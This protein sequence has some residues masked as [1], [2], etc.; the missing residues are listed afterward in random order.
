MNQGK[1]KFLM[2]ISIEA[3]TAEAA[4]RLIAGLAAIMSPQEKA[5]FGK[6]AQR[7]LKRALKEATNKEIPRKTY[8]N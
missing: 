2:R 3:T 8:E 6:K 4:E 7:E 5:A 1:N